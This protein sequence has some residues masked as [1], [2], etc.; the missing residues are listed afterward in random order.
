MEGP[1]NDSFKLFSLLVL[2]VVSLLMTVYSLVGVVQAG[3]LFTG[4]RALRNFQVWG[5]ATAVFLI[6]AIACFVWAWRL[7]RRQRA[8]FHRPASGQR[9]SRTS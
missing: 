4:E 5:S 1:M 8:T 6:G 3:I 7:V 2:G 9:S